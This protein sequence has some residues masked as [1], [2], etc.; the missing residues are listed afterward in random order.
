MTTPPVVWRTRTARYRLEGSRCP[1]C[2]RVFFPPRRL[3]PRCRTPTEPHQL[4]HR[5]R[6]IAWTLIRAK[7]P[8]YVNPE[9]IPVALIDL[10]EVTIPAQLTDVDP[11]EIHEGMEVELALR[12]VQVDGEAGLV[13]YGYKFRPAIQQP[14]TS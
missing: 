2:N 5:G 4:P 12:V 10:R 13:V 8:N 14:E 11:D 1:R 9:P 3:C 6:V 7:R